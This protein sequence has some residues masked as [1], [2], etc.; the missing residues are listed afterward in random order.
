MSM[1]GEHDQP[2]TQASGR[3]GAVGPVRRVS[4]DG[5]LPPRFDLYSAGTGNPSAVM[6]PY[7][8]AART[9]LGVGHAYGDPQRA[10]MLAV[11]EAIER[12]AALVVDEERLITAS[13]R[14]LGDEAL[15]LDRVPRCSAAELRRPGCPVRAV[16]KAEPIRWVAGTD[17]W[18]GRE[19]FLPAVM[20]YLQPPQL[21]GER[22]WIPISTG[23]A[24]HRS[25]PAAVL[26]A[27]AE[28]IERDA[29]AL[30][31]LQRMTLPKLA[32][33]CL[34]DVSR[35][36]IRWC[37]GHGIET[38]LFDATTDV[39]VPVVYC[40]QTAEHA[41]TGAQIVGSAC[42][43]DVSAAA[44]HAVM[45]AMTIRFGIQTREHRPRRYADFSS[46]SDGAAAMA[47]RKRRSAFGFLLRDLSQR[48]ISRPR[49]LA[50]SSDTERLSAVLRRLSELGMSAYGV[51][52]ST[53]ETEEVGYVA[54]RV[55]VPQ[56]QPMSC[57][58]L[59]QFRGH[60]RLREAPTRMGLQPHGLRQLNPY[61]QPVA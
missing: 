12:Y 45:E 55:V 11:S 25:L 60:P 41:P 10:R 43:F 20:V 9:G 50:A 49:A 13:A 26:A 8:G 14:S 23:C 44:E 42:G 59:A 6:R 33:E 52:I 2:V 56:M 3:L 21:P 46:V 28:V 4:T 19:L 37:R 36:L 30:T 16:S 38:Y 39:G 27:M 5:W 1:A 54:V 40:L 31:W 53:R 17:M 32:G 48:R 58:P 15:D 47:S 35:N 29:I 57:R 51:D 34:N 18:S 61:P 7:L 24:V 22:F